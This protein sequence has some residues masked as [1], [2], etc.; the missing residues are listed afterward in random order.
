LGVCVLHVRNGFSS[1]SRLP[2]TPLIASADPTVPTPLPVDVCVG[3]VVRVS[4]RAVC[5]SGHRMSSVTNRVDLVL[6][7]C[8]VG[9]ICHHVVGWVA[10]KMASLHSRRQRAVERIRH[11]PVHLPNSLP[12]VLV[13]GHVRSAVGVH[14]QRQRPALGFRPGPAADS[15]H[16]RDLVQ[17][18]VS[19]DR[20]PLFRG[21]HGRQSSNMQRC[22]LA[23]Y[24]ACNA[25]L[26]S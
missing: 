10:V 19:D 5:Y 12:A 22:G 17:T 13:Q 21:V 24:P 15:S 6:G 16:V 14:R 2:S 4:G 7:S 8:A 9:Q 3:G 26:R 18:F 11:E 20:S 1:L 25:G 23:R